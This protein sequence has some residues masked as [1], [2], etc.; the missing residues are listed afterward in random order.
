MLMLTNLK[1]KDSARK[2][3]LRSFRHPRDIILQDIGMMTD[4]ICRND[5]NMHED[6]SCIVG[7]IFLSCASELCNI[8]SLGLNDDGTAAEILCGK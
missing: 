2:R 4:C 8:I 3:I 7:N 1:G 6:M 5:S